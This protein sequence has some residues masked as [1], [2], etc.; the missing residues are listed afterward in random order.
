M[1]HVP[2]LE[3]SR[4]K[5]ESPHLEVTGFTE[6]QL[7]QHR[8]IPALLAGWGG[9]GN[10]PCS[11]PALLSPSPLDLGHFC[12][13]PAPPTMGVPP[14]LHMLSLCMFWGLWV[15]TPHLPQQKVILGRLLEMG[16]PLAP[17]EHRCPETL[18][19]CSPCAQAHFAENVTLERNCKIS[20][21]PQV[22]AGFL[23]GI[24]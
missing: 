10:S 19:R 9:K 21:G 24:R 20:Q 7:L 22:H 12:H 3:C 16:S 23:Q 17:F 6:D 18:E 15:W 1:G 13:G 4:P 11:A 14:A 2:F 5:Q 8:E